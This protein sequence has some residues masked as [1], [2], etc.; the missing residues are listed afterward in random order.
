[1]YIEFLKSKR[2]KSEEKYKNFKNLFEEF[3]T[4]SKKNC[5]ASFLNKYKYH[6]KQT[7]QIMGNKSRG[8]RKRSSP[9]IKTTHGITEKKSE[10]AKEFNKYFTSV[11]TALASEIPIFTKDVSE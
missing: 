8:N 3:K 2:A 9:A 10:I 1:M 6:T 11:G 7:W 4:K 5:Y